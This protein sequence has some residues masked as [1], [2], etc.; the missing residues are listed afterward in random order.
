MPRYLITSPHTLEDCL[1]VLD[2][3]LQAGA[4]YLTKAEWGC[5]AGVHTGW[6]IVEANDDRDAEL[7]VPPVFRR[8][9]QVVRLNQFTAEQVR[10]FHEQAGE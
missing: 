7:M 3:F 6:L 1:R 5:Q 8:N 4:H 2:G 9:A 10:K